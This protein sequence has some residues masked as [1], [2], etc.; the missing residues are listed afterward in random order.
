[1]QI[2][3]GSAKGR[4]LLVPKNECLRPALARMRNSLF[5]ILAPAIENTI[6]LDLFAGTGALGLEGLSR[7][8]KFCIFI[9]NN[10]ACYNA[11]QKNIDALGFKDRAKTLF[12]DAF[13]LVNAPSAPALDKPADIIFVDPPYRYYSDDRMRKKLMTLLNA[14]AENGCLAQKGK[15]IIE[16][17]RKQISATEF[18]TLI[19]Y[20]TREYGQTV[21]SF[22]TTKDN[23]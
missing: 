4:V 19:R 20:D 2:L 1:M 16:H 10:Y 21:L 14:L 7:G 11:L 8:A 13:H 22:F 5:N 15:L 6:C 23:E 3:G 17:Q 12:I 9:E 18:S